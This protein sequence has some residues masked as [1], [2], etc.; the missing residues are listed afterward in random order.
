M[1]PLEYRRDSCD[2]WIKN[3]LALMTLESVTVAFSPSKLRNIQVIRFTEIILQV[4]GSLRMM[5]FLV[6]TYRANPLL[7]LYK[8]LIVSKFQTDKGKN[9]Q[10]ENSSNQRAS[11][12][13]PHNPMF[14]IYI[15]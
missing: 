4:R 1:L 14:V 9:K 8:C 15:T 6:E 10:S 2:S 13:Y 12:K 11:S 7:K 5:S 3:H